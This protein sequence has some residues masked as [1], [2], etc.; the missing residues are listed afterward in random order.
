VVNVVLLVKVKMQKM[1]P[2]EQ[3]FEFEILP[4]VEIICPSW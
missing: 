4:A 2:D 3:I 1:K